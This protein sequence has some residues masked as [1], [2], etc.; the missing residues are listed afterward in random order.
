MVNLYTD[1]N[2]NE[3]KIL[4]FLIFNLDEE[5]QVSTSLRNLESSTNLSLSTVIKVLQD[6]EEKKIIKK[7]NFQET[8]SRQTPNSYF[9]LIEKNKIL[10]D[11]RLVL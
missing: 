4:S 5:N 9:L 2:G 7:I 11:A 8:V 3:F 1:L 6:L 10:S